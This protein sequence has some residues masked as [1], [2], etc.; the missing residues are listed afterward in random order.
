[1]KIYTK[2]GDSGE[3]ATLSGERVS[4][5]AVLIRT[6]GALDELNTALGYLTSLLPGDDPEG[7]LDSII[8]IQGQL[9]IIGTMLSATGS[10]EMASKY[11]MIGD[12][13]VSRMEAEIDTWQEKLPELKN[14]IISGGN[15]AGAWA[16]Y[17]RSIC[18]RTERVLVG[19]QIKIA[20]APVIIKY[21]NR[22]SDW[23]FVLARRL[24]SGKELKWSR[25]HTL[26]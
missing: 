14:F 23:L 15:P 9:I 17:C 19:A 26:N 22:L 1:M 4:K 24:N 7:V 20:I 12:A 10:P 3:T 8:R 16:H 18:R 21:V 13:E 5:S 25:D 6:A 11:P 2:T